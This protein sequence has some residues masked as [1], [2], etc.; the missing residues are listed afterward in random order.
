M[1]KILVEASIGTPE[2]LSSN[3]LVSWRIL[4]TLTGFPAIYFSSC[5][6]GN[7]T[8]CRACY[9]Y[10]PQA[11]ARWLASRFDPLLDDG[12]SGSKVEYIAGRSAKT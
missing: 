4:K 9:S 2:A 6:N 8:R 5:R 7:V 1:F 10:S 11:A 3:W 12:M